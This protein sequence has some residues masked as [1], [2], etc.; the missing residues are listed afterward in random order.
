M[1]DGG[2]AVKD[3]ASELGNFRGDRPWNRTLGAWTGL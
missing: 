1:L 3:P 2:Q